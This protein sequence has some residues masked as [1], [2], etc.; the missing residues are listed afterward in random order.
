[1]GSYMNGINIG[2]EVCNALGLK[3][4]NVKSIIISIK[5]DEIVS[6]DVTYFITNEQLNNLTEVIKTYHLEEDN[7][8]IQTKY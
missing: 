5:P 6:M 2:Q 3:I 8:K 4:T 1:M 7:G